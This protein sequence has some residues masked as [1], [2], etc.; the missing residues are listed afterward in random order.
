M[1]MTAATNLA[2]TLGHNWAKR[3][4]YCLLDTYR[5]PKALGDKIYL[6]FQA[7]RL[8]R[9]GHAIVVY[10][11]DA[12]AETVAALQESLAYERT[13]YPPEPVDE[14]ASKYQHHVDTEATCS[15]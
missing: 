5:Q 2:T 13:E 12:R 7:P 14:P 1:T 15:T 3:M 9:P 4:G 11:V 8:E 10:S 6:R